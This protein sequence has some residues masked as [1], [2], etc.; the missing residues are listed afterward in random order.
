ME[1]NK[2]KTGSL[3]S[4]SALLASSILFADSADCCDSYYYTSPS[5]FQVE[6]GADLYLKAA[7]LYQIAREDG[8]SYAVNSAQIVPVPFLENSNAILGKSKIENFKPDW[9][10]GV[11]AGI[12][13]HTCHD[14]W[15]L[16]LNWT[17]YKTSSTDHA[18][19]KD[20]RF[21]AMSQTLQRSQNGVDADYGSGAISLANSAKAFWK[22]QYNALDFEWGRPFWFGKC[23]SLHPFL[24][25][26]AAWI[27]QDFDSDYNNV[28]LTALT[29]VATN[30]A[31]LPLVT[32]RRNQ[33]YWGVGPR[34]GLYST[35][36]FCGCFG[37][38]ANVSTS[39]LWGD[40]EQKYIQVEHLE[41]NSTITDVN[42]RECYSRMQVNLEGTVGLNWGKYFCDCRYHWNFQLG[43]DFVIWFNHNQIEIFPNV[44]STG[45]FLRPNG[46]LS[47]TGPSLQARFDF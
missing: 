2:M 6:C 34:L 45:I 15:D 35:W 30:F 17:Y 43:W 36:S 23:T 32:V 31:T 18:K 42:L 4:I 10:F 24:G 46:N 21:L 13:Y 14:D 16:S 9:D 5:R 40:F 26:R 28:E 7:L 39:L 29:D 37:F 11:R 8:L 20:P 3:L 19:A 44:V 25:V 22:V 12:G 27:D 41:D 38:F 47:F 1:I 33:D